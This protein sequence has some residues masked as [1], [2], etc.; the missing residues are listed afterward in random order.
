MRRSLLIFLVL[1]FCD[2]DQNSQNNLSSENF[3]AYG[4]IAGNFILECTCT[5]VTVSMVL[6]LQIDQQ[7]FTLKSV[8][9]ARLALSSTTPLVS[10]VVLRTPEEFGKCGTPCTKLINK[11][12][13]FI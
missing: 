12:T 3:E 5:C 13:H 6:P 7:D 4:S 9:Q 11:Y 8:A 2:L 10:L 1:A